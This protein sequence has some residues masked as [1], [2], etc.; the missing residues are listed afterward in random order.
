MADDL[1]Q[2]IVILVGE[3]LGKLYCQEAVGNAVPVFDGDVMADEIALGGGYPRDVDRNR[4]NGQVL[5][6]GLRDVGA[7]LV[8][9]VFIELDDELVRFEKRYEHARLHVIVY[10]GVVPADERLRTVGL[11]VEYMVLGL[12]EDLEVLVLK[13][14]IHMQLDIV[15]L[16]PRGVDELVI[17]AEIAEVIGVSGCR[18]RVDGKV[19]HLR[20][21]RC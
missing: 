16:H 8:I 15:V 3:A 20:Y 10:L 6:N 11:I 21:L 14:G 4:H 17:Y 2:H 1:A 9:D 13:S 7:D 5:L 12:I 18:L 19:D